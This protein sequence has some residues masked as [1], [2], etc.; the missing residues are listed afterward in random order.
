MVTMKRAPLSAACSYCSVADGE[1]EGTTSAL[2]PAAHSS[3]TKP[4]RSCNNPPPPRAH[5]KTSVAAAA[6]TG[7]TW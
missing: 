3:A 4:R 1:A 5:T 2:T 6:V 7:E